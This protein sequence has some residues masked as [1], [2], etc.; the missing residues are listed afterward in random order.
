MLVRVI[1]IGTDC[2]MENSLLDHV[3]P[4]RLEFG[5][6]TENDGCNFEQDEDQGFN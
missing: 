1:V 4:E 2:V 6:R 3:P 5:R